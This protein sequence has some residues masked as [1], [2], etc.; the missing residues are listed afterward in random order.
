[1][2]ELEGESMFHIGSTAIKDS[3]GKPCIDVA[4][5]VKEDVFNSSEYILK[6]NEKEW[7]YLGTFPYGAQPY[8][9]DAHHWFQKDIEE[10]N[11]LKQKDISQ[12]TLH[13]VNTNY[14]PDVIQDFIDFRDYLNKHD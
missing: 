13:I 11:P 4:V 5:I 1:M 14:A 8:N 7:T 9:K 3:K 10:N 2:D 6:L 12:A